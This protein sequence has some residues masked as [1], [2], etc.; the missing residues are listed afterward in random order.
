MK[1]S[2]NKRIKSKKDEKIKW[3]TTNASNARRKLPAAHWIKDSY[4]LIAA[5]RFFTNQ[6]Q[7]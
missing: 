6:G 5:A 3:P 7:K 4:V 2:E 1:K